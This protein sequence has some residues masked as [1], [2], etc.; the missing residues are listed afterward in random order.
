MNMISQT[1]VALQEMGVVDLEGVLRTAVSLS[2]P[3]FTT[4]SHLM[5]N[6]GLLLQLDFHA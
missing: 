6:K 3:S 1:M 2:S 5:Q 4:K